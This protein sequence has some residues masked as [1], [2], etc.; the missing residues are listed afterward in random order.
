MYPLHAESES[1]T[2]NNSDIAEAID[3]EIRDKTTGKVVELRD[4]KV[5]A[6]E[7]GT[8][9]DRWHSQVLRAMNSDPLFN[10]PSSTLVFNKNRSYDHVAFLRRKFSTDGMLDQPT[11]WALDMVVVIYP[12]LVKQ[13]DAVMN[14]QIEAYVADWHAG[15]EER[16]KKCARKASATYYNKN[17][18]KK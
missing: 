3:I 12:P 11:A 9:A 17:L 7:N 6:G 4:L 18:K 10:R 1:S 8:E 15:K 16:R 5:V 14:T 13:R 2:A